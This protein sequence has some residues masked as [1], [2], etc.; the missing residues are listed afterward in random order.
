MIQ[1]IQTVFLFLAILA[2]GA[3]LW[4][5]VITVEAA[6]FSDSVQ[7]WAVGHSV[8]IGD[9][10]YIIFFSSIFIGTAMGFSLLAILLFKKRNIQMLFCWFAIIFIVTA[11]AFI[12]YKYYT[13]IFVGDVVWRKWNLLAAVAVVLEILAIVYIR[14]DEETIKSLD[15]LR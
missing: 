11:E 4:M 7:G 10:P 3:L 14:K 6:K 15:R 2:L 8:P 1:R 5:P 12:Y 9:Q 13:K